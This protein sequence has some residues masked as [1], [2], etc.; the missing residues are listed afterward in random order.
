MNMNIVSKTNLMQYVK[1]AM[2]K[3]DGRYIPV[4]ASFFD[5]MFIKKLNPSKLYPN[6]RDEFC[7]D[8][9]GPNYE[10]VEKYVKQI[11]KNKENEV[12]LFDEPLIIEKMKPDGFMLLNGHHR[13]AAALILKE[14]SIPVKIINLT[15]ASDIIDTLEKSKR[16]TR[17]SINLDDVVISVPDSKDFEK[18]LNF[19]YNRIFRERIRRGIP[20]LFYALH[21]EG[22]DVWIYTSGFAS[23]DYITQLFRHYHIDVDGIINGTTRLKADDNN[24]MKQ[25]KSLLQEKYPVTL[26]IDVDSILRTR[27]GSKEFEQF[28]IESKDERWANNV[29]TIVRS[30]K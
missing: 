18:P 30:L 10:I 9:I 8:E 16:N 17:A 12:P 3:I 7:S 15:H 27:S 21:E 11:T 19:P 13:W 14:K 20:A 4:K 25:A 23:T 29:I 24:K 26:H 22:Y 2:Q 28:E 6:P 5:Q 1:E